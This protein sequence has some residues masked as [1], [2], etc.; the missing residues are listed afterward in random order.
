MSMKTYC[1][2]LGANPFEVV[3]LTFHIKDGTNDSEFH[4]FLEVFNSIKQPPDDFPEEIKSLRNIWIIK[5]GEN[6]NRGTGITVCSSLD[7]I[8]AEISSFAVCSVTGLKRTF[9]LQKYIENP[10]LINKRKFDIR[11]FALVTSV[12]GVVQ[13]YF[14]QE[15]YLRTSCKEFSLKDVG[16][17]YIHLTNDAVQKHSEDYGKFEAGNKLSYTDFQRYLDGHFAG[18]AANVQ[19]DIVPQIRAIIKTTFMATFAKVDANRR[20][21]SFEILGYD[22]MVDTSLKV[23]LIEVNTNPCL[24]LSSP[25]LARV[26][27]AMLD[28][29]LRIAV[30]PYFVEGGG[31]RRQGTSLTGEM[32]SENKFELIFSSLVEGSS[33]KSQLGQRFSLLE[34]FDPALQDMPDDEDVEEDEDQSDDGC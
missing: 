18:G 2:V 11:C 9:I 31:G 21:Y 33:L 19:R 10:L 34:T 16:N 1:E 32:I 28:N 6:T 7:Q 25:L 27:P 15:G 23:W 3:P 30:D 12:H 24:E 13:G 4:R 8:K 22:F 29:A 20:Q 17:R 5:P 26:I 14:Y